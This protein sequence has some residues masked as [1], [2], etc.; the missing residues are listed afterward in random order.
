MNRFTF[1]L[2]LLLLFSLAFTGC[3]KPEAAKGKADLIVDGEGSR[4]H[5]D[6]ENTVK[7]VKLTIDT[8]EPKVT[9]LKLPYAEKITVLDVLVQAKSQGI[10]SVIEGQGEG[11]MIKSIRGI[12]NEGGGKEAKNWIFYVNNKP[13]NVS[14]AVY[15]LK[16]GD[17]IR[18]SFEKYE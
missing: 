17:A 3:K 10:D 18:W 11:A 7:E 2:Q 1:T 9:V 6:N 12:K 15:S 14:S 4:L 8:G 5:D 16:P 13:S